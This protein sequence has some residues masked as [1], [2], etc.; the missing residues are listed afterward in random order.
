M[1]VSDPSACARQAL[2]AH[3]S[4]FPLRLLCAWCPTCQQHIPFFDYYTPASL[5]ER[6]SQLSDHRDAIAIGNAGVAAGAAVAEAPRRWAGTC[7]T[8]RSCTDRPS[9]VS[10]LC[11]SAVHKAV[12]RQQ[13]QLLQSQQRL[14]RHSGVRVLVLPWCS[15]RFITVFYPYLCSLPVPL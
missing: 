15:V 13:H 12:P 7:P 14:K 10:F 9:A 1:A 8:A 11:H 6:S 5:N 2:H 4:G 3:H